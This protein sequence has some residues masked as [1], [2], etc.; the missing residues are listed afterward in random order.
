[1]N[2]KQRLIQLFCK[3]HYFII[4]SAPNNTS[5]RE[6]SNNDVVLVKRCKKC[7]HCYLN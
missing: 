2:I 4:L 3:H 7:G 6:V 1:M 5:L